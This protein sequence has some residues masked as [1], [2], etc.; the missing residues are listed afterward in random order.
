MTMSEISMVV[1]FPTS[2]VQVPQEYMPVG[3]PMHEVINAQVGG[4]FDAVRPM[5]RD[6]K[7]I[8]YVHDEGLLIGLEPNTLASALFG[9]FLC[10]PC[11]IVGTASE[12]GI[13]DGEDHNLNVRDLN[14][15][16]QLADAAMIWRDSVSSMTE[17]R[18]I[19]DSV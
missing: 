17:A 12:S 8:G 2:I 9:R 7:F 3:T 18:E 6:Q 16:R 11:V 19:K 14:Y 13:E 4:H 15:I 5:N 10:G 1:V